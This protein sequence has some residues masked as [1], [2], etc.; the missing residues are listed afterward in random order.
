M[1][2]NGA[3]RPLRD[4]LRGILANDLF[5]VVLLALIATAVRWQFVLYNPR[6]DGF[7]IYQGSPLSDGCSYTF[8]A[9]SIAQGHGIPPVQQPAV[10]PFYPIALACLYTWSGFSLWGI[11]VLNIA[12]A[13]LTASL[14][15]LCG[16]RALNRFCGLGAGLFFAIDPSQLMQTQ[17]AGTEPLGLLFFVASVY[18]ALQ[19]I[20]TRQSLLFFLT[21][22]FIGLSNLTRTLTIFTLPLF[23]G[24]ILFLGIRERTFKA[25]LIHSLV[26]IVGV[27]IAVGPWIAREKRMYGI[28]SISDNIGEAI[29]AASSPKYKAWT[30][31]VRQDAKADG[32]PDTIGD[33]YR[34][35]IHKGL[36]NIRG[37]PGFYF[38]NVAAALWQY[39]NTFNPDSRASPHYAETLSQASRSQHILL[40]F[41]LLFLALVSLTLPGGPFSA[42]AISWLVSSIGLA[43]VYYLLPRWLGCLPIIIGVVLSAK[44]E[45]RWAA[46]SVLVGSLSMAV[47]GSAIFANPT[48]FRSILMTDWLYLLYFLAAVWFPIE[49]LASKKV[50]NVGGSWGQRYE[51]IAQKSSFQRALALHTQRITWSCLAVLLIFFI[52]SGVRLLVL[53]ARNPP[54]RWERQLSRADVIEVFR[55]LQQPIADLLP[56]EIDDARVFADW[57]KSPAAGQYV[58]LVQRFNY[59]YYIPAGRL[60]PRGRPAVVKP[61]GRSLIILPQLDYTIAGKIPS[62]FAQ[63]PLILV[64][65]IQSPTTADGQLTRRPQVDGL[66]I[67][68]LD[69]HK[70]PDYRRELRVPL[71]PQRL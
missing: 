23:L 60:P 58:A 15:Y 57:S 16:A 4:A 33:R 25:A 9:I 52:V 18:A 69:Q 34:Y 50:V 29:Y 13:A 40:V 12:A 28:S 48:L 42:P 14:I 67:I 43:S 24:F 10:R 66:A 19:A 17:Q 64:G 47:V 3:T 21:G 70:R 39:A 44:R 49:S 8:K 27:A 71:P 5:V 2:E 36:E 46:A 38:R 63:Q 61:Y 6:A 20:E 55:H 37:D 62:E 26:M 11:A 22:L 45:R 30:P 53:T 1:I 56:R 68:P 51:Q 7:L 32:I 41:M 65:V 59:D 35:F 31:L 54:A